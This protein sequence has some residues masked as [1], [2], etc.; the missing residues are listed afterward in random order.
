[1]H[2]PLKKHLGTFLLQE[3]PHSPFQKVPM[4]SEIG[5]NPTI[6]GKEIQHG[7]QVVMLLLCSLNLFRVLLSTVDMKAIFHSCMKSYQWHFHRDM[8]KTT[9]TTFLRALKQISRIAYSSTISIWSDSI[10]SAHI[11][12]LS[13]INVSIFRVWDSI[14]FNFCSSSITGR[15]VYA[16]RID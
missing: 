5:K 2:T 8:T 3:R 1:M 11:K 13:Y 15:N 7:N 12:M 10:H 6:N 14:L 16:S 9:E 4:W